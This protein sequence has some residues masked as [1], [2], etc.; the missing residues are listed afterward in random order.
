[1]RK[2]PEV[3]IRMLFD[4]IVQTTHELAKGEAPICTSLTGGEPL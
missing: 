2:F 1:M 4:L 3:S